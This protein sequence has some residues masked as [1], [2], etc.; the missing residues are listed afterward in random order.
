MII[1][2]TTSANYYLFILNICIIFWF[3]YMSIILKRLEFLEKLVTAG[4]SS[5]FFSSS[6]TFFVLK[7]T[8]C[9]IHSYFN[10]QFSFRIALSNT[11]VV[12]NFTLALNLLCIFLCKNSLLSSKCCSWTQKIRLLNLKILLFICL[13]SIC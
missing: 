11:S 6:T 9:S 7:K 5:F 2:A 4:C 3:S 10:F 13:N 1:T 8:S 12:F